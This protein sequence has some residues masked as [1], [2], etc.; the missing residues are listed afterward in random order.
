MGETCPFC[1]IAATN[2]PTPFNEPE[3]GPS[4]SDSIS[5]SPTQTAF[6]ILSTD[7]VMAFLD[8]MPLTRGHVLVVTRKHYE[9]LGDMG[10][11][12][13]QEVRQMTFNPNFDTCRY[14]FLPKCRSGNGCPF[15]R[16]L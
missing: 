12:A 1:N 11:Q 2:P 14:S 15:S 4:P 6:M 5:D 3:S 13:S 16:G 9:K 10:V 8:I 7:Q